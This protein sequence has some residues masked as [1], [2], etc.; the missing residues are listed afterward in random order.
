MRRA[1]TITNKHDGRKY[2]VSTARNPHGMWETA[3]FE[4]GFLGLPKLTKPLWVANTASEEEAKATH[5]LI[6]EM[7]ANLP[8]G[9]WE[10]SYSLEGRL[11][12]GQRLVRETGPL[13]C[14]VW[15]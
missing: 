15:M 3:V 9:D 14:P 1:S 12:K 13:D 7:A 4:R 11:R 10:R 5:E 2:D 6:E 8:R